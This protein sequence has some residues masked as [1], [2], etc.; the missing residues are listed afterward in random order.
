MAL[1]T[2]RTDPIYAGE[3]WQ[4]DLPV[5]D[6]NGSPLD[7]TDA[8]VKV[9][10]FYPN[11]RCAA[12]TGEIGSGVTIPSLGVISWRFEASQ[13][14]DLCAGVYQVRVTATRDGVVAVLETYRLPIITESA[15]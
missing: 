12:L 3:T 15:R 9:E 11:S 14:A 1:V 6:E 13:T 4:E 5:T 7:L 2:R 10:L 8:A